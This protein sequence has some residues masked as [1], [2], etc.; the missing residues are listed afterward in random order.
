M[1]KESEGHVMLPKKVWIHMK[2]IYLKPFI[3]VSLIHGL[4]SISI[5]LYQINKWSIYEFSGLKKEQWHKFEE[6]FIDLCV[7]N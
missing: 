3:H 1:H 4:W 5:K 7:M 2:I 6:Q